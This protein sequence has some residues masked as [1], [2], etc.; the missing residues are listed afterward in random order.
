METPQANETLLGNAPRRADH[1]FGL[2]RV[3]PPCNRQKSYSRAPGPP[4]SIATTPT[5]T[6]W[7]W[8]R[9]RPQQQE[10]MRP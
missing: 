1:R 9:T 2:V 6:S 3:S 7:P 5:S 8:P 4:A 10:R